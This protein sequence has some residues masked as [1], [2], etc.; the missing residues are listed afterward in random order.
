LEWDCQAFPV[1]KLLVSLCKLSL[2]PNQKLLSL[3]SWRNFEEKVFDLA[4]CEEKEGE[5]TIQAAQTE[6]RKIFKHFMMR[7]EN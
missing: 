7:P 6:M 4:A 1:L 3:H 2:A 5:A